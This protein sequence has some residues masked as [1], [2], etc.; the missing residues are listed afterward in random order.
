MTESLRAGGGVYLWDGFFLRG[1]F[2]LW[3]GQSWRAVSALME[4]RHHGGKGRWL[5]L[6]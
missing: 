5:R 6:R 1:V 2:S 4:S 3:G